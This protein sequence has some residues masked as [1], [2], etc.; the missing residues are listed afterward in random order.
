MDIPSLNLEVQGG[1][2]ELE[3]TVVYRGYITVEG[4]HGEQEEAFISLLL[5]SH[6]GYYKA[7]A[8]TRDSQKQ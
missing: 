7:P 8:I 5:S 6:T 1:G 3:E 4:G 2:Q